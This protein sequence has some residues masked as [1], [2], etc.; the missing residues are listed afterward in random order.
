M[1]NLAG[2]GDRGD[3][4][5][6]VLAVWHAVSRQRVAELPLDPGVGRAARTGSDLYR[7]PQPTK[8]DVMIVRIVNG[9]SEYA[10][11]WKF[12]EAGGDRPV[13]GVFAEPETGVAG[14]GGVKGRGKFG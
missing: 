11:V 7:E 3:K 14:E 5:G 13:G 6:G 8:I 10:G 1:R 4:A 9:S 2:E 12:V